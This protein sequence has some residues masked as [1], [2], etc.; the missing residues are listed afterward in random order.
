M[1]SLPPGFSNECF[2]RQ[3]MMNSDSLLVLRCQQ[4]SGSPAVYDLRDRM[5]LHFWV[6]FVLWRSINLQLGYLFVCLFF[7]YYRLYILQSTNLF[8]YE[9]LSS[10]TRKK[11]KRE[12]KGRDLMAIGISTPFDFDFLSLICLSSACYWSPTTPAG[13]LLDCSS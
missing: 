11:M 2:T 10:I 1:V 3:G 7:S 12:I 5:C 13:K 8:G 6:L 4:T 9:Y